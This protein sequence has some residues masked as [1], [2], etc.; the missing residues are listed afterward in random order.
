MLLWNLYFDSTVNH[1]PGERMHRHFV[2]ELE[3]LKEDLIR[4]SSLAEKAI[5]S[6]IS[7]FLGRRADLARQVIAE[8]ERIN[9]ME[10]KIDNA[11]VDLL[12]LQQ[13]VASDLRLILAAVK[14]NNDLERIGDHA[15]NIAESAIQYASTARIQLEVELPKTAEMTQTMLRDALDSFIHGDAQ[16]GRHVLQTDD[17]I[18]N[19]NRANIAGL[20]QL[21]RRDPGSIDQALELI[22]VSRN[23]ERVAD[24][25]T[26]IAE[27]VVFMAEAQVVKHNIEKNT[28]A[29]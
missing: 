6:S 22:R 21:M 27:E 29:G 14:I 24:L 25:A 26:N 10:V 23:L 18:D 2:E 12:A 19:L 13:P 3:S 9:A 17:T 28:S 1:P 5:A 7:A 4:M 16:L 15:V 20:V 11:V 8:D